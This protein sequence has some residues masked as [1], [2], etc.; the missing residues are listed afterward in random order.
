MA[1]TV[2]EAKVREEVE[3][4][5]PALLEKSEEELKAEVGQLAIGDQLLDPDRPITLEALTEAG[6]GV[7]RRRPIREV[8]CDPENLKKI[9]ETLT[10][11]N[12]TSLVLLLMGLLNIA[13]TPVLGIMALAVLLLR[14]GLHEYCRTVNPA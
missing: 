14:I 11:P 8:V 5:L 6:D 7:V 10:V 3:R 9:D 2:D 13:G 4:S 12:V 1:N